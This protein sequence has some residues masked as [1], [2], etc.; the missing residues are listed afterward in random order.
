MDN[1]GVLGLAVGPVG[2]ALNP[3]LD[4]MDNDQ[5]MQYAQQMQQAGVIRSF[6]EIIALKM[7]HDALKKQ[8]AQPPTSTVFNDMS[9]QAAPPPAPGQTGNG[10]ASLP[11]SLMG[12]AKFSGG[13]IVSFARG[14]PPRRRRP[15]GPRSTTPADQAAAEEAAARTGAA[16]EGTAADAAAAE[17][18]TTAAAEEAAADA[19]AGVVGGAAE[20]TGLMGLARAGGARL[21]GLA[22]NPWVAGAAIAGPMLYNWWKGDDKKPEEAA[23]PEEPI[24]MSK[25][26]PGKYAA[27]ADS[28]GGEYSALLKSATGPSLGGFNK[29]VA[30]TRK[31]YQ[32]QMDDPDLKGTAEDLYN[33]RVAME[34]KLGYGSA[35][36]AD[37]VRREKK[38]A[39]IDQ[40]GKG[41]LWTNIGI[42]MLTKGVSD[43]EG[44]MSTLASLAGAGGEG[45]KGW[46][47]E[48]K[49][50]DAKLDQLDAAESELD[51][52]V[53]ER[54]LHNYD[55]SEAEY[56]ANKAE[57]RQIRGQMNSLNLEAAKF[58][59]EQ[60]AATLGTQMRIQL[61][62]IA[63]KAATQR[64]GK[65][66]IELTAQA[67][68]ASADPTPQ[69]Q[70][71][72]RYLLQRL[73][74]INSVMNGTVLAAQLKADQENAL[75]NE[76]TGTTGTTTSS[77]DPSQFS[78]EEVQ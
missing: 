38:R 57:I 24:D 77:L 42:Q 73:K 31:S 53:E 20:K 16:A 10:V 65:G 74:E 43:A 26:N 15:R 66:I 50:R 6:P 5:F 21:L 63:A 55:V 64:G 17:G 49:E 1:S 32:E 25:V 47:A 7:Q 45:I 36:E 56:K 3:K 67:A 78:M 30:D 23:A 62:Q 34:K 35:D 44:G 29:A 61:A 39:Q 70:A 18:A 46:I 12:N 76:G 37:R 72:Y 41:S 54:K 40:E 19:A 13:G 11:N 9:Q 2:R 28:D 71:T 14:G 51:H 52:R 27:P 8:Q 22:T 75:Y 58:A 48:K 4:Q 60:N 59:I 69:G 33:R 68:R